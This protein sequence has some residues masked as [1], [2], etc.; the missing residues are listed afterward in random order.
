MIAKQQPPDVAAMTDEA[1]EAA[2][3][4]SLVL[5]PH[6]IDEVA[7]EV[8][9]SDFYTD[10]ARFTF[11]AIAAIQAR[12]DSCDTKLLENELKRRKRLEAV[13][14]AWILKAAQAVPHHAHAR[15][16]ARIVREA[17][18]RRR[19]ATIA[20]RAIQEAA[21]P[22]VPIADCITSTLSAI[23]GIELR[24]ANDPVEAP[25]LT[26]NLLAELEERFS[27]RRPGGKST[28]Y[29]SIDETLGGLRA[30]QLLILAARPGMGKSAL[31]MN[32]SAKMATRGERVLVVSL[33]MNKLELSER[34]L[35][36]EAEVD[37]YRIKTGTVTPDDRRRIQT[38]AAKL[39]QMALHVDD[40]TAASLRDIAATARRMVRKGGL[41]LLVID[42]LQLIQPADRRHPREQQVAEIARG[43]KMLA[44]E[45]S[46]PILCLAQLNRQSESTHNRRPLLSHLRESGAIEQ[47]A[48]VVLFIHREEV[49][50]SATEHKG[51]AELI[52]AKQR[53]GRCGTVPLTW[54]GEFCSFGDAADPV[55]FGYLDAANDDDFSGEVL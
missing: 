50:D 31:A 20:A 51:K 53:A 11:E 17:A 29:R 23:N 14:M 16:Y 22:S 48:D 35:C 9:A 46:I 55:R 33:E 26:E 1:A 34:L 19:L 18:E 49:Y 5:C 4:G 44:G 28:G 21:D 2:A 47:D 24:R 6:M 36:S 32:V 7:S 38:G 43:L 40:N 30:G 27:G 3:V 8:Q 25:Q 39:S 42:Y 54:R 45:L 52:V 12:G 15:H 37:G 10:E 41:A 13:G